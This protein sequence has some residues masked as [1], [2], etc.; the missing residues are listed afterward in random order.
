MLNWIGQDIDVD[1][2]VYRGGRQGDSSSFRLGIVR[3]IDE[4]KKTVRVE[5]KYIPSRISVWFGANYWDRDPRDY[6]VY[7]GGASEASTRTTSYPVDDLVAVPSDRLDY[8]RK[9][10]LL[11]K[12]A[13]HF[14]VAKED[15]K[16]FEQDFMNG[17]IPFNDTP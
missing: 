3:S 14:L 11:G 1:T 17:L 8:A 2:V 9:R 12:A 4:N 13:R 7:Q 15:F 16:Q 5:W 6:T 10:Y